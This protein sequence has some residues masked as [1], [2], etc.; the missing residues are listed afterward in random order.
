MAAT[1]DVDESCVDHP[2]VW[3]EAGPLRL[4]IT[5]A[6]GGRLLSLT[7]DGRQILW[8]NPAL[9]DETLQPV[10][11]HLIGPV[12]GPMSVWNN[13]GGSKTWPAP[14]G[15]S[16]DREWAGPPDPVLDSGSYRHTICTS[17]D[18]VT[19]TLASDPEPRT[20]LRLTR[21]IHVP[22]A[23]DRVEVSLQGQNTADRAT[24][25]ALWD[26][27]QLP[28]GGV[29]DVTTTPGTAPVALVSGTGVPA[30]ESV[31][32]GIRVPAQEV[33]GKLGF[34]TATG[35]M[36]YD[37]GGLVVEWTFAVE[38]DATYPDQ[39]SRAEVWMEHPLDAPL[40]HL[41]GLRPP[42]RI[43]ECEVLGPLREL[44]PGASMSL[45]LT[46]RVR[47]GEAS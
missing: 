46:L 36:R 8:R 30:W 29:L 3:V 7:H 13:Y 41:G 12:D 24:Q 23:G 31:V 38:E 16:S 42:A 18:G 2:V 20:G 14:Q 11:G 4:G 37:H 39:G 25:W 32:D 40:D 33:V 35:V 17:G 26:V 27:V 34:P 9:L 47:D 22:A 1:V 15:W 44:A 6:L 43:V 10:D 19:V 5:P 45:E 28:G 21:V